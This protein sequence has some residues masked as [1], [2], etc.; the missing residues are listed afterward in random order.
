M[1]L[2]AAKDAMERSNMAALSISHARSADCPGTFGLPFLPKSAHAAGPCGAVPHIV[3]HSQSTESAGAG[4]L[5]K[6]LVQD[7]H[8]LNSTARARDRQMHPAPAMDGC[9][10]RLR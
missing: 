2:R 9:T 3:G 5:R 4:T 1:S 7:L 6:P 8:G 10:P